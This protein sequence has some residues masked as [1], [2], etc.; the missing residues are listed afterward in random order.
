MGTGPQKPLL[1]LSWKGFCTVWLAF[2]FLNWS[3]FSSL[4]SGTTEI[5][6]VTRALTLRHPSLQQHLPPEDGTHRCRDFISSQELLLIFLINNILHGAVQQ[7][8]YASF[9]LLTNT[10]C[11]PDLGNIMF[12]IL[13]TARPR[14][15]EFP[16]RSIHGWRWHKRWE[17]KHKQGKRTGLWAKLRNKQASSCNPL[18]DQH[19]ISR[20]QASQ[21]GYINVSPSLLCYLQLLTQSLCCN[22]C[23]HGH[24]R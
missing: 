16:D 24:K 5:T 13:Q 19:M 14:P 12:H 20:E 9:I 11:L 8:V 6:S 21:S 4:K 2:F 15:L 10:V 18:L 1:H 7:F 22:F 23:R 3:Q 17:L